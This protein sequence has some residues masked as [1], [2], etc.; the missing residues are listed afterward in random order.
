MG[1]E[2]GK[3]S[4]GKDTLNRRGI[5]NVSG[6]PVAWQCDYVGWSLMPVLS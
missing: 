4:M 2:T 1:L 5:G 6:L 3:G